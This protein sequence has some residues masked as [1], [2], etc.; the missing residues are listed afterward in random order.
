MDVTTLPLAEFARQ[1]AAR[2]IS[3]VDAT[4]AYLDR[5]ERLDPALHAWAEVWPEQA[6]QRAQASEHR[7]RSGM[8]AGLLEGVP[9]GL[10]DLV[11]VK[12][13]ATSAGSTARKN[14]QATVTATVARRL[15]DA[16]AILLG[17]THL[18]EFAFGGWGTNQ[19]MGTPRNPWDMNTA[20]IPGGSS[21]GSGVA[22]A[23]G[24][25]AGAVG[26]D[27][28][29][30]VRIPAS[31]CGITGLKT[32]PGLISRHGVVGLSHTLDTVGP[33][34]ASAEDAALMLQVMHGPDPLD[35]ETLRIP[36]QDFLGSLHD[37]IEG[38]R[39]SVLAETLWRPRNPELA[40]RIDDTCALL[41][42]LGC[43]RTRS[44]Q[45]HL[46][47]QADQTASGL[48]IAAEAYAY[49]GSLLADT[50]CP[51]DEAARSRILRG[52]GI[53]SQDYLHAIETRLARMPAIHAIFGS[54]DFLVLPTTAISA[55]PTSEIRED[56]P[57]PSQLTRF[58]NYYGLSAIAL[59]CGTDAG[60]MPLSV[61]LVAGPRQEAM[62][63]RIG[64]AL[65]RHTG[66]HRLRPS[67]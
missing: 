17:K 64:A 11:D 1:I 29:G 36:A 35:P 63:L 46:D 24:M 32:T 27:T 54:L 18:V 47:L 65:Q 61:Q 41:E 43:L 59:P 19:G 34:A 23:A 52:A 57:T 21:S 50:R 25:A 12:G 4:R 2:A 37:S 13:Y 62:L 67:L 31:F 7:I 28:G 6:M 5:I 56:D 30:S 33:M 48:I 45:P 38:L 40:G 60:G 26:T 10:K 22:V 39:F 3:P 66:Y 42:H 58:V 16:G 9:L 8:P 14:Q 55:P 44:P 15:L 51:G 53:S 20:R 49:H